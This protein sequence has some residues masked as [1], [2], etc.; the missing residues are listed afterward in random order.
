M[1]HANVNLKAIARQ[2]MLAR[3]FRPD[4]E[5]A[6]RA[7]VAKLETAP[8]GAP[9][10]TGV[11]D[12]RDLLWSSI[13][14]DTSRDLDQIEVAEH[15]PDGTTRVRI[16]IADVDTLV[17]K[18]SPIDL[19]AQRETTTVYTGVE[20]FSMIPEELSTGLTSLNENQ[21]RACIVVEFVHDAQGD[22]QSGAAYPA[23]V[24]NRAQLAY[25][26]VGA[27]LEGTGPAPAK[28][29]VSPDLQAQLKLQDETAQQLRVARSN[30][31]A[32]NLESIE[33][34][35]ILTNGQIT[36]I[37]AAQR[38]RATELI[39]DFM[40][41]A[42]QVIAQMLSAKK[43]SSIRRVVRTP[44]RWNRIVELAANLG[45]TL[46]ATPDSNALNQ[47]IL[48]RREVDPDHSPDLSLAVIKLMGPGE[49]VVERPGDPD[50]G[51][52]GLAVHDYTHSTAP[53]RRYADLIAQRLVKAALGNQPAP[54]SDAELDAI[55]TNCTL[56][57]DAA[58]KVERAMRKHIA[59]VALAG[60]IGETFDAIVTGVTPKGTYVRT[61][62]P[63]AEGRV[64]RGEQGLD[65]G[66]RVRVKL[67]DTDP[68][69]GFIDFGR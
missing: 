48:K 16:G 54:Y 67:L 9:A 24:R 15:L 35:P 44:E 36:D 62:H 60:R 55:A 46:P 38:N 20:N 51:H 30:R 10:G 40:I 23:L 57:E 69:R 17:P 6:V 49:Y 13:D 65:V 1:N 66:D 59:A 25:N 34:N 32:L 29:A 58:K 8:P 39:E 52:F 61:I 19:H 2:E 33:P 68:Q 53:N 12:L 56:K 64:M 21:D 45:E 26:G 3:G 11:K 27:W 47:F 28:V 5:D 50:P 7:Q 43:V 31:G 4:F 14:N 37:A 63:P 41:A 22:V 42:N 18:G